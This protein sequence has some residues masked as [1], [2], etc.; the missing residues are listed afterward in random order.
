MLKD[1]EMKLPEKWAVI[2]PYSFHIEELS[3][4]TGWGV[5]AIKQAYVSSVFAGHK[6]QCMSP[7]P[8]AGIF[9]QGKEWFVSNGYEVL[10]MEE[11]ENHLKTNP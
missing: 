7:C 4:I 2:V 11:L 10:S 1:K 5:P 6:E 3:D 8:I 9:T